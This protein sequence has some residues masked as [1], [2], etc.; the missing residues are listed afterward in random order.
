[1]NIA[2]DNIRLISTIELRFHEDTAS[3]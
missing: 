2:V 3:R 1:M